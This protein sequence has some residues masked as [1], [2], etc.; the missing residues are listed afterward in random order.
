MVR[1]QFSY[2]LTVT[3]ED[4]SKA[5]EMLDEDGTLTG[6]LKS[7]KEAE[8]Q[9]SDKLGTIDEWSDVDDV[10]L[11]VSTACPK[12]VLSLFSVN[13]D[14]NSERCSLYAG[15]SLVK[16]SYS[17][18]ISAQEK[19]DSVTVN[20]IISR[21]REMGNASIA[22]TIAAEFLDAPSL[23]I[24][25]D[26]VSGIKL[27]RIMQ[28]Y[29]KPYTPGFSRLYSEIFNSPAVLKKKTGEGHSTRWWYSESCVRSFC[30]NWKD[31]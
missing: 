2:W 13:E 5:M 19:Y 27:T 26:Y 24:V 25:D 1:D 20:A 16:E 6:E 4:V 29:A 10:M 3:G 23:R 21:L 30:E 11:R 15:G 28:E 8:Y 14:R 7:P 9:V 22:N 12:V 18:V 17:R 31:S